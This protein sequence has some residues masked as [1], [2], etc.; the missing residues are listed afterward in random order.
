MRNNHEYTKVKKRK[1]QQLSS[2][3]LLFS[4]FIAILT[5]TVAVAA[6]PDDCG[7]DSNNG[8]FCGT[9][10]KCHSYNCYDYFTY[11]PETDTGIV[12]GNTPPPI[13]VCKPDSTNAVD[14]DDYVYNGVI[15][16]CAGPG[17]GVSMPFNEKCSVQIYACT[18]FNCWQYADHT[19]F[20]LFLNE[21]NSS[22]VTC[23]EEIEKENDDD[24]VDC[25]PP[26]FTYQAISVYDNL[27]FSGTS[28][29]TSSG[30]TIVNPI[31]NSTIEFDEDIAKT[32][33]YSS[34]TI[35]VTPSSSSSSSNSYAILGWMNYPLLFSSLAA[36]YNCLF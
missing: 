13:L 29:G 14:D 6:C 31:G 19:S 1:Q 12:R 10:E 17:E 16:G 26:R 5:I 27:T 25:V 21:V 9:D 7:E 35:N 23:T 3:T 34:L 22:N 2:N 30:I 33:M 11:G 20:D 15:Y 36:L 28:V 4:L 24:F 8:S 18:T 32:T